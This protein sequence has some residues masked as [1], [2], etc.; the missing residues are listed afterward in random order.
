MCDQE[1]HYK[2]WSMCSS[3]NFQ[4]LFVFT[5]RAGEIYDDPDS[6][7]VL[8]DTRCPACDE[9][10]TVLVGMDEYREMVFM[11]KTKSS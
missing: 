11:A 4:G 3:C 7:G 9:E 10:E 2:S 6:L 8:M 1:K 5:C